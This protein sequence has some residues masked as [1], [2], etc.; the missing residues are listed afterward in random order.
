MLTTIT[1]SAANKTKTNLKVQFILLNFSDQIQT[2][3]FPWN[4]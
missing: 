1:T 3:I 2:I 4:F